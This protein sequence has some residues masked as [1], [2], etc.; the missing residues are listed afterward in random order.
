MPKIKA[1]HLY[2]VFGGNTKKAV[3]LLS[4]GVPRDEVQERTGGFGAV[5]DASLEIAEGELFVIMGL[6]GSGK[7]TLVRMFNRLHPATS[8]TVE[9]D[10]VDIATLDKKELRTLRSKTI[11]MVFQRFGLFPHLS[12]MENVAW[13]LEVQH[14]SES[15]R[16]ERA[17]KAIDTVGLGGWETKFPHELSGGMQQRVGLARALATEADILLMD[18]P[19]SALDPLIKREMQTLLLD[20]QHEMHKTIIFITHDLNEAMRLGDRITVLKDGQIEQTGEPDEILANPATP[21]VAEFTQD[22][23]RSRVLTASTVMVEPIATLSP[24]HQ[25]RAALVL[26]QEHQASDLYVIGDGHRLL[27][28]VSDDDL[29]RAIDEGQK[30]IEGAINT[31]YAT[32]GPDDPIGHALLDAARYPLPVAV[33]DDNER[34]VG[35]LPRATMLRALANREEDTQAEVTANGQA[36]PQAAEMEGAASNG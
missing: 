3:S 20:L 31:N 12:I 19:F 1:S 36:A 21:Y 25:P 35:V 13:G 16:A 2:K 11:S 8:G 32:V 33:C 14:V 26:M 34:L 18:E 17:G 24:G 28:G 29:K 6:S 9:I 23:D 30:T 22:V 4:E 7:S 10:G 27:G 5:I 15:E